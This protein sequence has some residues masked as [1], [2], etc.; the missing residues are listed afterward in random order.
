MSVCRNS[1]VIPDI[2][3]L[4][5]AFCYHGLHLTIIF[6][7]AFV[8]PF[9]NIIILNILSFHS[10]MLRI[11]IYMISLYSRLISTYLVLLLILVHIVSSYFAC[12]HCE[13]HH[14]IIL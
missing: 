2:V 9:Y 3:F 12:C 10:K 4:Y 7:D 6:K 1:N 14:V 13:G 11:Y 8:Q 5:F